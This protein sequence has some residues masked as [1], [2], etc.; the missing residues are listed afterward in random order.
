[1][2]TEY[3]YGDF[4]S[5]GN[6]TPVRA[7][8]SLSPL[9]PQRGRTDF[10]SYA[11]LFVL[12]LSHVTATINPLG[13]FVITILFVLLFCRNV[14]NSSRRGPIQTGKASYTKR[15]SG[16]DSSRSF[17]MLKGFDEA[18]RVR[19]PHIGV[20]TSIFGNENHMV[21]SDRASVFDL[22]GVLV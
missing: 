18:L 4:Y 17:C 12:M 11:L 20:E 15:N 19:L 3:P 22:I 13:Y 7:S 21:E 8:S 6:V 14:L 1:M 9:K 16:W 5:S 10:K 2:I